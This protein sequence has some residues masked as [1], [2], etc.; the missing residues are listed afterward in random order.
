MVDEALNGQIE[1]LVDTLRGRD[2]ASL[3]LGEVASVTEVLV[4]TMKLYFRSIDAKIYEECQSL[5]DY[6]TNARKEIASLQPENKEGA[7]IPRAGRELEAIVAQTEEATDTI[8]DAAEKIMGS[9][10]TDLEAYQSEIHNQVMRI[11]EACSFQ[12][13]TGQRISKVVETLS[14]IERRSD[15]LKNILGVDGGLDAET[16]DGVEE[17]ETPEREDAHL[18]S[19]PALEGEG[20]DQD[21]VD[22]LMGGK[23]AEPAPSAPEEKPEGIPEPAPEKS[24]RSGKKDDV[25]GKAEAGKAE[26]GKA[27]A[28]KAGTEPKSPDSTRTT[29]DDIDALFN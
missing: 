14:Y 2:E 5:S 7:R 4:K 15:K 16:D 12:D 18:L 3:S 23:A 24:S 8:M 27:E 9:Q 17:D 21:E 6:I 10:A 25:P 28:E 19:G 29:Q 1:A 11:F 13:I 22:A 26:A 20:I